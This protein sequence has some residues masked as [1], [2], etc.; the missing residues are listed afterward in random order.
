MNLTRVD[1]NLLV[2]F[3]ALFAERSVTKAARW[4]GLSQPATSDA[5]R[6]LRLL[7]RDELFVRGAGAMQPSPKAL[8]I[9]PGVQA[10]LA[11]LRATLGEEVSFA[12]GDTLQSFTLAMTD[13]NA[14]VL[15]PPLAAHL[16]KGAPGVDLHVV[17]Y[18]KGEIGAMLARGEVDLALGVFP[19]P[20][21]DAVKTALFEERFVG[22]A[23]RG[24]PALAGG[25]PDL[26]TFVALP[27][28]LVTVRREDRSGAIDRE[29]ARHGLKRRVALTLPHMLVLPAVL[30]GS[31]L[32]CALPAR[33][34]ERIDRAAVQVFELPI[35]IPSW[36]VE[37]LWNPIAR[38]DRASAWLRQAIQVVAR[39]V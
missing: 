15:L 37:M 38:T 34:A 27:H 17:G 7:F 6:R 1:L 2:A 13:Y 23:R 9:A 32:V 25:A 28:A 35:N 30:A 21:P 14:H 19:D 26:A 33:I 24:H 22:V 8:Q 4:L 3:E 16:R 31:D 11:Q 39:A 36:T 20:P 29:L 10:A 12:P 5:L 18:E